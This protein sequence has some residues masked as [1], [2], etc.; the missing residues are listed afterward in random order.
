MRLDGCDGDSVNPPAISRRSMRATHGGAA[1]LARSNVVGPNCNSAQGAVEAGAFGYCFYS[2][3]NYNLQ[4]LRRRWSLSLTDPQ[5]GDIFGYCAY[6][7]TTSTP[8]ATGLP[9]GLPLDAGTIAGNQTICT[10][11]DPVAFTS[12]FNASGGSGTLTYTWESS[13]DNATWTPIAASNT[14]T[15]DVPAGLTTNTYY[16]RSVTDGSSTKISNA[17]LVTIGSA[18]TFT[19]TSTLT[20][21]LCSGGI[22]GAIDLSLTNAVAP[23]TFSWNTGATMEDLTGLAAGTYTVTITDGTGCSETKSYTITQSTPMSFNLIQSNLS[24]FAAGDGSIAAL[25]SGGQSPYAYSWSSGGTTPIKSNLAAGTYILTVTDALGCQASTSATLTQPDQI[26][27]V[28]TATDATCYGATDGTLDIS[29]SGGSGAYTYSWNQGATSQNLDSIQAGIYVLT[30]TDGNGCTLI[31]QDTVHQP[32]TIADSVALGHVLCYGDST[33]TISVILTGGTAPYTYLWSTGDTLANLVN[34]GAGTYTLNAVDAQLCSFS[35][36]YTVTEPT[37]AL[38]GTLTKSEPLCPGDS[39]GSLTLAVTGGMAPYT[40]LWNTGDTLAAIDSLSPGIYTVTI[41]DANGCIH[42]LTDTI[43]A[44]APLAINATVQNISCYGLVN[45]KVLTAVSGGTAPYTY[46]WNDGA[47]TS[48]NIV[49]RSAGTYSLVVTDANGCSVTDTF[50]IVQ[51]LPFNI[52][53]VETDVQC[54]G[55]ST[56]S[57]AVTVL[58]ATPPYSYYWNTGDTNALLSG[59][60]AGTYTLNVGDAGG[61]FTTLS[62][63]LSQP[64]A[65]LT[66][67]D[68]VAHLACNGDTAGYIGLN[69]SGGTAP[70]LVVWNT[71]DTATSLSNLMAGTYAYVATDSLGCSVRDTVVLTEPALLSLALG[72]LDNICF[73]DSTGWAFVQPSGGLPPYAFNWS[74]GS[75]ADTTSNLT[76]GWYTVTVTDS[77]G[78]SKLDSV[79]VGE[80]IALMDSVVLTQNLCAND[81]AASIQVRLFGAVAP[82]TTTWLGST[83]TV[84]ALEGDTLTLANLAAGTYVLSVT[85]SLGCMNVLSY[86]LVDPLGMSTTAA[87]LATTNC[88]TDSVGVA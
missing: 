62:Y 5:S 75:S 19:V 71:G 16:R 79:F 51:P 84:Q 14:P 39:T 42:V 7:F 43:V 21:V 52:S 8:T 31:V 3:T 40:L 1:T 24:C 57:I 38:S 28:T 50:T 72:S 77:L 82:Y 68:S 55:D 85:D 45:G 15:Y 23:I 9:P 73:G 27:G 20:N 54:F 37:A 35:Q 17:V 65:A 67:L 56:G 83:D 49:N 86:T 53:A 34:L 63:T 25:V 47:F 29:I 76:A 58:G 70:Y 22:T 2:T 64:L 69:L 11:G 12:P 44:P 60:P 10:G 41:M 87:Q 33:G 46:S 18:P 80:G 61:C 36:T 26:I 78:C 74:N 6:D 13:T 81:T 4:N 88:L 48:Q 32:A 66:V 30:I 59:V